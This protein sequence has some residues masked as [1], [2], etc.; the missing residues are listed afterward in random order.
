MPANLLQF[1][2]ILFFASVLTG[3]AKIYAQN[4]AESGSPGTLAP[5][6]VAPVESNRE[7]ATGTA[8]GGDISGQIR[9][10]G[11]GVSAPVAIHTVNPEFSDEARQKKIGGIV[12]VSLTVDEQGM[13]EE[14]RRHRDC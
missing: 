13:P 9:E 12:I 8:P 4:G 7:A 3:S 11:G 5:A 6:K 14:D 10:V 2:S 1:V